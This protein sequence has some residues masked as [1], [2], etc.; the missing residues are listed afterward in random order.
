[1]R[2]RYLVVSSVI[3]VG[4]FMFYQNVAQIATH[5]TNKRDFAV[6]QRILTRIETHDKYESISDSKQ[7]ITIIGKLSYARSLDRAPFAH[8]TRGPMGASIV[9][10]GVFNC[11]PQR[12]D[13]I[14]RFV[15]YPSNLRKYAWYNLAKK[16]N[17][18]SALTAL[19]DE[20]LQNSHAWPAYSSI[21]IV[22]TQVF[23]VLS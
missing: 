4:T 11:Q 15:D 18:P 21:Q 10:C 1:M 7:T 16:Q 5:T 8:A 3:I 22:G 12:V 9:H 23:V 19:V 6:A 17:Y 2:R 20:I 13:R 14:M